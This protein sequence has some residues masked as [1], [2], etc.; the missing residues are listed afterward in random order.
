MDSDYVPL[1]NLISVFFQIRD[2]YMNLQSP[3]VSSFKS[4]HD[5]H[6]PTPGDL[7]PSFIQ[8][9]RKESPSGA[10]DILP[11]LHT[12]YPEPQLCNRLLIIH[13][14]FQL[15][16]AQYA[17]N[18]GFAEDLTEGKFSFPVVHGVRADTSNRQLLREFIACS[19]TF[20]ITV[21]PIFL[22]VIF[23]HPLIPS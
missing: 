11:P 14:I 5:P 15:A 19:T 4:L 8:E 21:P 23:F 9:G 1:V 12:C 22:Q 2:D 17:D 20:S 16:N 3:E 18:K 13:T 7:L 10:R 6:P